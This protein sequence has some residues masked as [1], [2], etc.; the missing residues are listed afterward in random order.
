MVASVGALSEDQ[1]GRGLRSSDDRSATRAPG[2]WPGNASGRLPSASWSALFFPP[3]PPA[4]KREPAP[5]V[6]H[7]ASS[8]TVQEADERQAR[9]ST[10][11]ARGLGRRIFQFF[12]CAG[13]N[14]RVHSHLPACS[15]AAGAKSSR[16]G[17]RSRQFSLGANDFRETRQTAPP[18]RSEDEA[19]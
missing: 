10:R 8:R 4:E 2:A 3:A 12:P 18:R 14:L 11:R 5:R 6:F 1:P 16:G 17:G 15:E 7:R 19:K 13:K 9:S